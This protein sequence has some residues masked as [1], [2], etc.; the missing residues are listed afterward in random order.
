M[1][2]PRAII[3]LDMD[4]FFVSVERKFNPALRNKP[5]IVGGGR[6]GDLRRSVVCACSYETRPFGVRS[7]MPMVQALRLCPAAIIVPVGTSDYGSETARIRDVISNFTDQFEMTSPDEAYIDLQGTE[8]LHGPPISAADKLREAI[9][10]TTGLPCSVGLATSKTV[11]KIASKLSKPGGMFAVLPGGESAILRPLQIRALP[12]LGK[13]TA[14]I[15][16]HHAI[17]TLGQLVD[18][19]L[20]RAIH[21][22]G[23]HGASLWRRAQGICTSPVEPERERIQISTEST[24]SEDIAD[25]EDINALLARMT[26]KLGERLR[27]RGQW[28]GTLSIK[29]RY[30]DFTTHTRQSTLHP[31]SHHDHKL[32]SIAKDLLLKTWDRR[33]PLRLIGVGVTGL[34]DTVQKDLFSATEDEKQERLL[35]ALDR[36]RQFKGRD[37]LGWGNT[38]SKGNPHRKS[39]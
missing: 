38:I 18:Q 2:W 28:A 12:G 11:A 22:L 37:A 9:T 7:A 24:F 30:P 32:L 34:T 35:A 26:A 16:E 25:L 8:L 27:A 1:D 3:H 29:I 15:I 13:K 10:V 6:G 36:I 4:T 19:G 39:E 33:T 17:R 5:V 14:A 31:L 23:D 20:D 21:L